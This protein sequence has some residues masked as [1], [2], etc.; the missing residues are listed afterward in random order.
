MQI[1]EQRLTNGNYGHCLHNTQ[2]FSP[3]D[4]WLVYDTRNDDTQ[5]GS[6]GSIEIVN[7]RSGSVKEIYRTIK[8]SVFGPGVGAASFSPVCD[9]VVFIHGISNADQTRP[10]AFNRR[11]AVAIDINKPYEPIFLDARHITEPFT[12]GALRGGTHAHLWS[13]D[14]QWLSFT[15]NDYV[16]EELSTQ[17]FKRT[18]G[19]MIPGYEVKVDHDHTMENHSGKMFSF[20]AANLSPSPQWGSDEID[21]AFDEGWIGVN[22]Y[23]RADQTHQNRAIAFQGKVYD[24]NGKSKAELFVIDLPDVFT[25]SALSGIQGTIH[26]PPQVPH[27]ITQRRLT[28]TTNGIEGPRHWLRTT[29][30]GMVIGFLNKDHHGIVQLF[31][32]SPNG[33]STKQLTYVENPIQGPFNFSP[34]GKYAAFLSNNNVFITDIATG[35]SEQVTSHDHASKAIG[36]VSW[37]NKG[38]MITY[39]R[40]I[41]N[42]HGTYLQIFLVRISW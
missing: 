5:I 14:G 3:N 32:I 39:N 28:Y 10:Y 12:P 16:M 11:T 26:T 25:K 21:I 42:A 17:P 40:Y 35:K 18:V 2:C 9:T 19:V 20:I 4:E 29:P 38:D 7:T 37:S 22:G 23:T 1:T 24:L 6:T 30:D 36:S 13:G 8:Q 27:D 33:G 15:Y 34:D 41:T 31:G